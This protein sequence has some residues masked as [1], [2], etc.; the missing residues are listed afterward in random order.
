[1]MFAQSALAVAC[2]IWVRESM[3]LV[4]LDLGLPMMV[5]MVV[6]GFVNT[7]FFS[8]HL[9]GAVAGLMLGPDYI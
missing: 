8:P 1:M 7:S 9:P 2:W 6:M 4:G 3:G 5:M